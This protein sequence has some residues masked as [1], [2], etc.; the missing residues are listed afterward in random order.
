MAKG[1][2]SLA[3]PEAFASDKPQKRPVALTASP[4]YYLGYMEIGE[5]IFYYMNFSVVDQFSPRKE[6]A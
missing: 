3:G 6:N 4:N 1:K 2:P 5:N